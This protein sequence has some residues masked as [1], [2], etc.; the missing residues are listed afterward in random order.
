[1]KRAQSVLDGRTS[2]DKTRKSVV[3]LFTDGEP[4]SGTKFESEVASG[5]ITAAKDLK[6]GGTTV[7]TVGIFKGANPNASVDS[8]DNTN[9]YMHA[10][11]SNYPAASYVDKGYDDFWGHHPDWKWRLGDRAENSNYYL[12]ASDANGLN[13]VFQAISNEVNS[14]A[15]KIDTTSVLS[16]TLSDMFTFNP[17]EG[18]VNSGIKV[19]KQPVKADG[20]D[21]VDNRTELTKDKDGVE[22]TVTDKKLTVTGFDYGKNAVTT[23]TEGETT[24]YSGSKLV[25]TIPIKPDT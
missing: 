10:V 9:K 15:V 23:K 13:A 2:K 7:F 21:D 11:S 5:A 14:L 1:M 6:D 22:V 3:I 24:T 8:T 20:T 16:D 4:T 17:P 25:V 18:A 12:A 19:Y